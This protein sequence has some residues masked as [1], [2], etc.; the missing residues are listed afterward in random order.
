MTYREP[1]KDGWRRF[2]GGASVG[3]ADGKRVNGTRGYCE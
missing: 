2:G 1:M 3:P